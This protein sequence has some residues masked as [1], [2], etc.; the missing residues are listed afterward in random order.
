M[1]S[2]VF[3]NVEQFQFYQEKKGEVVFNI[4]R[5]DSYTERDTEYIRSELLKKLGDDVR[6]EISFVN[7]IP[8]TGRGKYRFLVQKLPVEFGSSAVSSEDG[9]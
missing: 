1:H 2:N 6:L 8:R 4:V 5:K 7:H 3:D 9:E